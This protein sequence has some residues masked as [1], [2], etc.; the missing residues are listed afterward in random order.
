MWLNIN[1]LAEQT[2]IPDTTIRRY[3]TK[4]NTFFIHKGGARSRRYEDKAVKVLIRI[5]Q[6]YDEGHESEEVDNVLRKEFAVVIDGDKVEEP[7]EKS[8]TPALATAEDM[9]EIKA[10]LKQQ[11]E[12]NK[13]LIEKLADQERYIKEVIEK[14]DHLLLESVK[15]IQEQKSILESA[16]T[17][18]QVPFFKRLFKKKTD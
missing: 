4:F 7:F 2:N 3:I 1:E 12:F 10:A 14:K 9:A 13:L 11:Q 15:V 18:E 17:T 16:A 6:L 5:K 8:S